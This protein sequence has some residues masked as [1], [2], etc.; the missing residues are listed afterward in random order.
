MHHARE[1]DSVRQIVRTT[2]DRY[3]EDCET[4]CEEKILVRDGFYCGRC[5][6]RAGYRAVWFI[7]EHIVKF[8]GP[9][10]GFLCG[11]STQPVQDV[12][13]QRRVA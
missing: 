12:E 1:L 4:E 2:F 7:E 13:P 11:C 3:H 10:G 5:F 8:Y 6:T 9:D